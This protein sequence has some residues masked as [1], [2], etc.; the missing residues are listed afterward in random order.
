MPMMAMMESSVFRHGLS[1]ILGVLE[2]VDLGV[3][4]RVT[5]NLAVARCKID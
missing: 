4:V 3:H 5:A 2:T 1:M